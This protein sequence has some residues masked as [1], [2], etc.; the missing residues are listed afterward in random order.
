MANYYVIK[1]GG[2]VATTDDQEYTLEQIADAVATNQI[3]K[4]WWCYYEES[5][6]LRKTKIEKLHFLIFLLIC[7]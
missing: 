7:C 5:G 3:D 4:T 6:K 1:N 2:T